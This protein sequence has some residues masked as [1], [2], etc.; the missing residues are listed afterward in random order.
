VAAIFNVA[1]IL[2]QDRQL[3]NNQTCSISNS[4]SQRDRY[5]D[6]WLSNWKFTYFSLKLAAILNLVAILNLNF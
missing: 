1:A 4:M 6:W 2:D 5:V 3:A